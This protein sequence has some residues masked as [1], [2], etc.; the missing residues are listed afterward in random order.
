MRIKYFS[1][2]LFLTVLNSFGYAQVPKGRYFQDIK[3]TSWVTSTFNDSSNFQGLKE[4]GLR[5]FE[6]SIDS[7][8]GEI[9][10]WTFGEQLSIDAY[11]PDSGKRF[12]LILCNYMNDELSKT[13]TIDF[14]GE[15]LHFDYISVSTGGFVILSR[16][17][18]TKRSKE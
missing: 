5:I 16:K 7:L 10:L 2:I 11:E 8:K 1:I 15:Q 3:G 14:N 4:I 13:I 9:Y 17:K 18:K 6:S 12:T